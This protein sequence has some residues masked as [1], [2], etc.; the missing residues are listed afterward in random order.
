MLRILCS[1]G[2]QCALGVQE[3]KEYQSCNF[4]NN[5]MGPGI[6]NTSHVINKCMRTYIPTARYAYV[7]IRTYLLLKATSNKFPISHPELK[8]NT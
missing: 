1:Q 2:P 7:H 5:S 3:T 8:Q 6:C 4:A